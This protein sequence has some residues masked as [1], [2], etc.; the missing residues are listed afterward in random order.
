LPEISV[1]IP[2]KDRVNWVQEAVKSV[3]NQTFQ[4]FEVILVDDGSSENH[5]A[6]FAE[7]DRRIRYL[8]QDNK[9]PAAARNSGIRSAKGDY[10]A[11]LDS[12]DLFVPNKLETQITLMKAKP[13]LAFSHTS[14]CYVDSAGRSLEV[15]HSGTFTGKV[16][17]KIYHGCPIATP[18]VVVKRNI[19]DLISF[20]ETL[21][22]AEDIVLWIA[23]SR[24]TNFLGIDIPLTHVRIHGK[25]A[26][27]DP[28]AQIAG[29]SNIFEYAF[30]TDHDLGFF[31][32]RFIRSDIY[33]G[34]AYLYGKQK[35]PKICLKYLLLS[36]MN[37]PINIR[38]Y[39]R[40]AKWIVPLTVR[41]RIKNL[42]S[43][44]R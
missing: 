39:I 9:G 26:I 16:Y 2:F 43:K 22:L 17:P 19:F 8:R 34:F 1:I 41:K 5:R 31:R 3:L 20:S 7:L 4:D 44:E 6:K 14:Y 10:I 35:Q 15:I 28:S 38:I 37:C 11:F 18:T 32:K 23:I 29:L 25:N 24:I 36:L 13:E 40:I 12:D 33:S 21:H 42:F 30:K 27:L